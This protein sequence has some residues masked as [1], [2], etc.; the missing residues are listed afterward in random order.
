[1]M[2][3][4]DYVF[5]FLP[6]RGFLGMLHTNI[7]NRNSNKNNSNDEPA[8]KP[9]LYHFFRGLNIGDNRKSHEEK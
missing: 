8:N 3:I 1:M 6:Q 9:I 4:L 7:I 2:R 5:F